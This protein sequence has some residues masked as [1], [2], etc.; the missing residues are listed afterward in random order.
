MTA[1]REYGL[2]PYATSGL[3][4]QEFIRTTADK[5]ISDKTKLRHSVF[6]KPYATQD[7]TY[8]ESEYTWDGTNGFKYLPGS[9][10]PQM[11][12]PI[13]VP[14]QGNYCLDLWKKLFPGWVAGSRILTP[15]EKA[16]YSYYASRCPTNVIL[17]ICCVKAGISGPDKVDQG[18]TA[19]YSMLNVGNGCPVQW[20]AKR[21]RCVG[22]TYYA[23][24]SGTSDTVYAEVV[25]PQYGDKKCA[26]KNIELVT[27]GT[28]ASEYILMSGTTQ[29]QG[30]ETKTLSVGNAIGGKTYTWLVSAGGGSVS[31]ATGTSTTYSA[32]VSNANCADNPTIQLKVGVNVCASTSLAV[33]TSSAPAYA[34]VTHVAYS[35]GECSVASYRNNVDCDGSTSTAYTDTCGGC[36]ASPPDCGS[37]PCTT[38]GYEAW[39]NAVAGRCCPKVNGIDTFFMEND[40][41]TAA[42]KLDGCCPAQLL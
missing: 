41:R 21:G 6:K 34:A 15:S 31:P 7:E 12:T 19:E 24:S 17:D 37:I 18:G 20:G 11:G 2:R 30:G 26:S 14:D 40:V 4:Y 27:A 38:S 8:P 28:C 9:D 23:P 3:T 39:C 22:G 10:Y 36:S 29:M 42:M 1:R 33:N 5:A 13:P 25:F 35:T 32:P 16:S